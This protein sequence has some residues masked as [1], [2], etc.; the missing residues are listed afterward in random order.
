[1]PDNV[2]L[3]ISQPPVQDVVDLL[4]TEV[5]SNHLA[6]IE[7]EPEEPGAQA[8]G[9]GFGQ[10]CAIVEREQLLISLD[11]GLSRIWVVVDC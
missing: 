3:V 8:A 7:L 2:D 11:D 6:T 9:I 5:S 4:D 1:M 10:V